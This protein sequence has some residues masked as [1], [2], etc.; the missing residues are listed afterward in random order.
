MLLACALSLTL[1]EV[2]FDVTGTPAIV[3]YK[4]QHM[5][6]LIVVVRT[7]IIDIIEAVAFVTSHTRRHDDRLARTTT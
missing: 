7:G 3:W 6:K 4:L 1:P 5:S 2:T